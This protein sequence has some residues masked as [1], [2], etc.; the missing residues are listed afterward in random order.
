MTGCLPDANQLGVLDAQRAGDVLLGHAQGENAGP[1]SAGGVMANGGGDARREI[2]GGVGRGVLWGW[3]VAGERPA[4]GW[5]CRMG[6]APMWPGFWRGWTGAVGAAGTRVGLAVGYDAATLTDDAGGKASVNTFRVGVYGAQPVG[7][8]VLAG[9][10]MGGFASV[11]TTRPTGAGDAAGRGDGS[12]VAG[13]VEV[14][15]PLLFGEAMVLPA[16]GLRI[17]SASTGALD[18]TARDQ[19]FAVQAGASGAT[20]VQ[21]FVQ[22]LVRQGFVTASGIVVTPQVSLGVDYEAGDIDRAV[23]VTAQDG[24]GF[25]AVATQLG[26]VVGQVG[27]GIA[28]GRGNWALSARYFAQVAGNWSAQTVEGA[29]QVRF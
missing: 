28:A 3:R 22:V 13:G 17:A 25:A 14:A 8:F 20:S 12:S 1:C 19:A 27:A 16:A 6:M 2:A 10:V 23:A 11:A 26:R 7:G 9:D 24:S 15:R 21:P 5:M 29:V 18:E 4:R